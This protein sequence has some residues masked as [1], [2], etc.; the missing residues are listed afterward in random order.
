MRL[1]SSI[2]QEYYPFDLM[3]RVTSCDH[4]GDPKFLQKG[5]I[6]VVWGGSDISPS[7]YNRDVS[8]RTGASDRPSRR[9]AIEWA[10]MQQA[11]VLGIPIIGVCRGAQM[12]CALAGGFLIQDVTNHFSNHAVVS[13]DGAEFYT[14]S[15]HHQ[16]LYPFDVEHEMLVKSKEKRSEHYLDV[17][18]E[19]FVPEEPEFVYF[20]KVKGFAI[21]WHPEAMGPEC[22]A[23]QFIFQEIEKRL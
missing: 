6:L 11:Q 4:S 19:I 13:Y 18:T 5:D 16:M 8:K 1:V 9:D 20:P 17:D 22:V 7:L 15:I 12:L 14:N 2:F 3:E 23:T 21:Q 10:M